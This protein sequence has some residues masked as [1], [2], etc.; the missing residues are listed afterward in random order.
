M[1]K[2]FRIYKLECGGYHK[3]GSHVKLREFLEANP[4]EDF[5]TFESAEKWLDDNYKEHMEGSDCYCPCFVIAYLL[6]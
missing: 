5:D 4:S 6:T 3:D 1:K 2:K